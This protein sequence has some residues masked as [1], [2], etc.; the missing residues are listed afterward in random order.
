M[1]KNDRRPPEEPKPGANIDDYIVSVLGAPPEPYNPTGNP[2]HARLAQW[3]ANDG[4]IDVLKRD[5][6]RLRE[7]LTEHERPALLWGLVLLFMGIDLAAGYK[8][9]FDLGFGAVG[10]LLLAFGLVATLLIA[11]RSVAAGGTDG[12]TKS[13]RRGFFVGLLILGLGLVSLVI[14]RRA[15]YRD[16]GS[17]DDQ[18]PPLAVAV[19]LALVAAGLPLIV[20]RLLRIR[21]RDA[22]QWRRYYNSQERLKEAV[23]RKRHADAEIERH[24]REH[25]EWHARAER[26]KSALRWEY[27]N[28]FGPGSDRERGGKDDVHGI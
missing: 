9:F 26:E 10:A 4:E 13:H 22:P 2:T 7:G 11:A 18:L 8:L 27:P 23:D 1:A 21:H 5:H 17:E 24:D 12:A 6:G 25:K 3:A 16:L 19:L 28:V 20:E 14:L 15:E